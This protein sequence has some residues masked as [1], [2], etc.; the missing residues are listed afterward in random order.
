[1]LRRLFLLPLAVLLMLPLS[2]PAADAVR[3]TDAWARATVPGQKVAGVYLQITSPVDGRLVAVSAPI[4][5]QAEVH[6]MKMEGGT[7]K[8]RPVKSLELPAGTTVKLEPGGLHV[9]LFGLEGPL[10]F[11]QQFP[12]TLTVEM[13]GGRKREVTA[14]VRVRGKE[15]AAAGGGHDH[16]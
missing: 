2:A 11:G 4:A 10:A 14:Q 8:M 5:K 12:L 9:M 16:H 7:M 15:D 1:M 13:Q 6:F 3:V